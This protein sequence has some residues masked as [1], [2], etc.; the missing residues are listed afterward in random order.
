MAS[1]LKTRHLKPFGIEID[2]DLR[3]PLSDAEAAELKVLFKEHDLLV[4]HNQDLTREQQV[5]VVSHLSP[6]VTEDLSV[7]SNATPEAGLGTGEIQYHSD[8]AFVEEPYY[9]LSLH[10]IKATK[11]ASSTR[12]VNIARVYESL[13][14]EMKER[15]APLHG[16]NWLADVFTERRLTRENQRL[17]NAT[18]PLVKQDPT[19]GKQCLYVSY[20]ETVRVPELEPE[21]SEALLQEL[22][23]ILYK[24]EN[25]QEHFWDQGDLLIWNNISLQH[26]RGDVSGHPRILQRVAGGIMNM[27]QQRPDHTE[28]N[29][30]YST[31]RTAELVR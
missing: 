19:T 30:P 18:H 24:P 8:L 10:A 20:L 7:V 21:E 29:S 5:R 26:A 25:I 1:L 16:I 28:A 27:K 22:F 17:P 15:L 4:F 6:T 31:M 14:A 9:A 11:G 23:G 3:Q 12:F 13:P 2:V